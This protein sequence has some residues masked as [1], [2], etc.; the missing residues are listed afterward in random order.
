MSKN[1]KKTQKQAERERLRGEGYVHASEVAERVGKSV[2]T[3]Y[4]WLAQDKVEGVR[5]GTHRYVKWSSVVD[6]FKKSDPK[7]VELLGL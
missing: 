1:G 2:Q 5:I 6:L 3:V 7:A 4:Y